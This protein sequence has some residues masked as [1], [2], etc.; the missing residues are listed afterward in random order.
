[1]FDVGS[2]I[3][4]AVQLGILQKGGGHKMAGGFTI[5]KENIDFFRDQ[6]IKDYEE[7]IF[8]FS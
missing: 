2:E 1:V 6:L 8:N 5:K 3:I 7:L 4:K